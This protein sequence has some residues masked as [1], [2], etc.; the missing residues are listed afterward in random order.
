MGPGDQNRGGTV[1]RVDFRK[2]HSLRSK[3]VPKGNKLLTFPMYR[4]RPFKLFSLSLIASFLFWIG[5]SADDAV[6]SIFMCA[7]AILTVFLTVTSIVRKEIQDAI[8]SKDD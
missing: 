2:K 3:I 6:I 7:F 5:T 1:T 8:W 4:V